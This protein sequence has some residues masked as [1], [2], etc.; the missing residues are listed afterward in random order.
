MIN[1]N[2]LKQN[3]PNILIV[4]DEQVDLIILTEILRRNDCEIRTATDGKTALLVS[5][6][7]K[8]DLILL[9]IYMPGMDGFEV[10][11]NLQDNENLCD[12]PIIFISQS[13]DPKNIA[14]GLQM[15]G[16]DYITKPFQAEEVTARVNT[17][18][19]LHNQSKAL[20]E[21]NANLHSSQEQLKKFSNYLQILREEEKILLANEIHDKIGQILVALKIEMGIWK[22]K[23]FNKFENSNSHDI[24][25]SFNKLENIVD[26]TIK[27]ARKMMNELK[28]EDLELLGF[29]ETAKLTSA[30]FEIVNNIKCQFETSISKLVINDQQKV[31]L[32]RILKDALSNIAIHANATEVKITLYIHEKKLIMEI[33]DNGSGFS[34]KEYLQK[35]TFGVLNLKERAH[36]IHAKLFITGNAAKGTLVKVEIPY[37]AD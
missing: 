13:E 21:S 28:S 29:I 19:R 32:Y 31:G 18:L 5:E 1:E 22:K 8:P 17:H 27:T 20:L 33:T 36:M 23:V 25:T 15:G 7:R 12:I 37:N 10:C 3:T 4:D 2:D 26:N 16:V 11:Q 6:E 35:G 30:E 14:K 34:E 24:L 9:D